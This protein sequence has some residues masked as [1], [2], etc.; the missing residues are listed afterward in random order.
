MNEADSTAS[1]E[2]RKA[3]Q[4][5]M[6]TTEPEEA[7]PVQKPPTKKLLRTIGAVALRLKECSQ[8][9][10]NGMADSFAGLPNSR[11]RQGN[12]FSFDS[13]EVTIKR[14]DAGF[15]FPEDTN[16]DPKN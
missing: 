9:I 8:Q 11:M 1:A 7:I 10:L 5:F 16:D 12:F 2:L 13:D 4:A 3:Y 15:I 14:P 6:E